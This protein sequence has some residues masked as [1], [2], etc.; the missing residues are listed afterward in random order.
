M[1]QKQTHFA[2]VCGQGWPRHAPGR[3]TLS[4]QS[5]FP[6]FS[7]TFSHFPSPSLFLFYFFF[8]FATLISSPPLPPTKL[9]HEHTM[10]D[11]RNWTS[12]IKLLYQANVRCDF[13]N[14]HLAAWESLVEPFTVEIKVLGASSIYP[15]IYPPL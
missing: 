1:H 4:S 8:F 13:Y 6:S 5:L 3:S 11:V 14:S 2:A 12:D 7:L 9:T 15:H 10:L